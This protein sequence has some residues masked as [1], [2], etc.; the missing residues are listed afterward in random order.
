[1]FKQYVK[2]KKHNYGIEFYELTINNGY[3][4]KIS[5]FLRQK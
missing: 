4:L 1:M 3:V 2:N 5:I